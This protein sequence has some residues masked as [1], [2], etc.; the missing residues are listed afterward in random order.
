MHKAYVLHDQVQLNLFHPRPTLP[1]W[2][3]LPM[4]VREAACELIAQ[5]LSAHLAD[6][7]SGSHEKEFGNE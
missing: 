7:A 4:E 2:A 1:R 5:V 6:H 3:E